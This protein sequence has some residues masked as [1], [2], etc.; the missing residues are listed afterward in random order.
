M[1]GDPASP[2]T[3]PV[4]QAV[5]AYNGS[6]SRPRWA[7]PRYRW[8]RLGGADTRSRRC[9]GASVPLP[10]P[11]SPAGVPVP[12]SVCRPRAVGPGIRAPTAVLVVGKGGEGLLGVAVPT[13]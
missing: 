8:S 1:P 7:G 10:V 5:A 2:V 11:A 6:V 9:A 13:H 4:F 12:A 3:L